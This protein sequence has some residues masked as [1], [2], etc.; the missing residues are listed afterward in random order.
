MYHQRI[1][2]CKSCQ[3]NGFTRFKEYKVLMNT[4]FNYIHIITYIM[5][6]FVYSM[7]LCL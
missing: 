3:K 6:K 4:H 5:L 7:I 1:Y 2:I